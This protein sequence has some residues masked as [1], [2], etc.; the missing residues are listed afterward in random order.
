MPTK[1]ER[2]EMSEILAEQL[3]CSKE[4]RKCQLWRC[5]GNG[6]GLPLCRPAKKV[7]AAESNG[8]G[9]ISKLRG[10]TSERPLTA[11]HDSLARQQAWSSTG[12]QQHP[13][14]MLRASVLLGPQQRLSHH[15][16]VLLPSSGIPPCVTRAVEARFGGAR[17]REAWPTMAHWHS[18]STSQTS[19]LPL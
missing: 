19:R 2:K 6:S 9:C 12:S 11:I 4:K 7:G 8:E 16:T 5:T 17:E 14:E 15:H 3:V 13:C 1:E 10:I 18:R